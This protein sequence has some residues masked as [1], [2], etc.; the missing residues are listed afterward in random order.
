[1]D[2]KNDDCAICCHSFD[3][4]NDNLTK[5][6]DC[7]HHFHTKCLHQLIDSDFK[8]CPLCNKAVKCENMKEIMRVAP[9]LPYYVIFDSNIHIGDTTS[10]TPIFKEKEKN[11]HT[12]V[13]NSD[14]IEVQENYITL[15]LVNLIKNKKLT[16]AYGHLDSIKTCPNENKI[17]FM[18]TIELNF[19]DPFTKYQILSVKILIPYNDSRINNIIKIIHRNFT[20]TGQKKEVVK[21]ENKPSFKIIK[22]SLDNKIAYDTSRKTYKP[23]ANTEAC[24]LSSGDAD[25]WGKHI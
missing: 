18:N 6:G 23:G 1:M 10:N 4:H 12:T 13:F 19:K 22:N 21:I 11:C 5:L 7:G 15:H 16:I 14:F 8:N 17:Y 9:Q 20:K 3:C 25:G 2:S 24:A